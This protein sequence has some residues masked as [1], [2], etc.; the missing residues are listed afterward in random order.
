[1]RI[2][3]LVTSLPIPSKSN[4][5][6]YENVKLVHLCEVCGTQEILTPE[7]GFQRGWD[8]APRMY[9]FRLISPRTCGKCG[10]D[11]TVWWD[12]VVNHKSFEEL[13]EGQ[14]KTIYRILHEP[15]SIIAKDI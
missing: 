4:S 12:I 13:T 15:E 10:I 3:F 2:N 6:E 7:E 9:P 8:Y 1:M 5:G 14:R 11:G